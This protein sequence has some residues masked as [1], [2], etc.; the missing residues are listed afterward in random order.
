[1]Y[2]L[3][4]PQDFTIHTPLV[5]LLLRLLV[6]TRNK[7]VELV[8]ICSRALAADLELLTSTIFSGF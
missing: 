6:E 1:M 8:R 5:A 7:G 2:S 4:H 3:L